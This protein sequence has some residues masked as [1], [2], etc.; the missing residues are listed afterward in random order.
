MAVASQL[1]KSANHWSLSRGRRK[2]LSRIAFAAFA[3][4]VGGAYAVD[5]FGWRFVN[6]V[7]TSWL[8]GDPAT[9]Y[10]GWAYFRQEAHLT[11]PLGWASGIG[12]PL[13]VPVAYF[14]SIPLVATICWVFGGVLPRNFQ[15]FGL[16]ICICSILQF[17][18]GYRISRFRIFDGDL[19]AGVLG[20]L[21]FLTA[22]SFTYRIVGHVA[23][24]SHWII[25]AALDQ[26]L[27][28]NVQPSWRR[29]AAIGALCFVAGAINPYIAA[30]TLLICCAIY[31][32]PP[33]LRSGTLQRSAVGIVIALSAMIVS[34]LLFGFIRGVDASQYTAEGFGLASMNLLS[35]I[36]PGLQ[37]GLL[38]KTQPRFFFQY[39]GYNYLGLGVLA[40]AILSVA[41][42]PSV[43]RLMVR[44]S[45]VPAIV[46]FGIS[47][48]LALSNRATIG[49][50]ELYQITLPKLIMIPLA[51]FQSSGR[52]FWPGYYLIFAAVLTASA[53]AFRRRW[54]YAVLAAA[55]VVQFVDL[56]PLRNPGKWPLNPL[57]PPPATAQP[58]NAAWRQLGDAQRHLMVVPAWQCSPTATPGGPAYGY[59]IFGRLA[60]EQHMTIN[61]YYAGR[62]S[63]AQRAFFCRE[64]PAQLLKNG[65]EGG[66]AY[67]FAK[68]QVKLVAGLDDGPDYCRY[69]DDYVLCSKE[70]G[71]TGLDP[72]VISNVVLLGVGDAVIFSGEKGDKIFGLGWSVP[73]PWGR[74]MDGRIGALAFRI[75]PHRNIR[76]QFRLRAFIPLDRPFQHIDVLANGNLVAQQVFREPE[77]DSV[78]SFVVS[79][80]IVSG[81]GLVRL[82]FRCPDAV[83]P[84]SLAMNGDGREL[85]IGLLDLHVADSG[86]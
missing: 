27:S 45:L 19:I 26:L 46:V 15:Y 64:Q 25:L 30:M 67:V 75:E 78:L 71:R 72:A 66:T 79:A 18:F 70:S 57:T 6:P 61:S 14:D 41:R 48:L 35:P 60:L 37:G 16:Y 20:G 29:I 55:L 42:Y 73:E 1:L 36:D 38:L 74:W 28:A 86:D 82:T 11:F 69:L 24:G 63:D 52:M 23:L 40:L 8:I 49:N 44:R 7:N 83:S 39:E 47:L 53:W 3:V 80:T 4:L 31:A 85:S 81:D 68:D 33:L 12:Y 77:D 65:L 34:L 5:F 62:Y 22:P 58:V 43:L 10:I 13:G 59:A 56:T 51:S 50:D 32:R 9:A 76:L 2:W 84:A 17:Y 21:F 54:L